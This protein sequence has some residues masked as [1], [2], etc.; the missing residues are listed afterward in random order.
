MKLASFWMV[1]ATALIVFAEAHSAEILYRMDF[2]NGS[3]I[4]NLG[5][6]PDGH[7]FYDDV[8][9]VRYICA[10]SARSIKFIECPKF[11][12]DLTDGV[13]RIASGKLGRYP[14]CCDY[15]ECDHNGHSSD[16]LTPPSVKGSHN[17]GG[18]SVIK[19]H[20]TQPHRIV[21]KQK[22]GK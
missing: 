16:H 18:K 12:V 20:V 15:P 22:P 1:S 5:T 19:K 3:C 14:E 8:A 13:C 6:I 10:A 11:V 9:C 4:T 7:S 2:A 21:K 17:R